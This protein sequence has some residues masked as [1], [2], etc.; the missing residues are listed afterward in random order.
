[1]SFGGGS[2]KLGEIVLGGEEGLEGN[3]YSGGVLWW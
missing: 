1:M 2:Q 3:V